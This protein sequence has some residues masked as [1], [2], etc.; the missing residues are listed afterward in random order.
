MP[1]VR[2]SDI[3]LYYQQ[4][5]EGPPVLLVHHFFGTVESWAAV[6]E[7]LR[8]H[9]RVVSVD[10]RGHGRSSPS[11]ETLTVEQFV[12]DFVTLLRELDIS[13]LHLV[14]ASIGAVICGRLAL[15]DALRARSLTMIGVPRLGRA[16]G[17]TQSIEQF[18][19]QVFSAVEEEYTHAHR[20]HGPAYARTVLLEHFLRLN[21][22]EVRSWFEGLEG[23]RCP[24]LVVSGDNDWTFPPASVLELAGRFRE[25]ELCVLPRGGHL[26]HRSLPHLTA[27]VLLDFLLRAEQRWQ[28]TTA[29]STPA[30]PAPPAAGE[31]PGG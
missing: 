30:A 16:P 23:V 24:V 31:V 7:P 10:L 13:S 19:E 27:P 11:Q 20:L 9:F 6:R 1:H 8:R 4:A 5:G 12:A 21:R 18:A 29:P 22:E 3:E 28:S 15:S 26:P 25:S 2:V 14:G 17:R